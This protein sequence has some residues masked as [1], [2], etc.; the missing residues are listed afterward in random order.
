MPVRKL[1]FDNMDNSP[2]L[3]SKGSVIEGLFKTPQKSVGN[4]VTKSKRTKPKPSKNYGTPL[5][6][7]EI[8]PEY[9]DISDELKNTD[10]EY[11]ELRQKLIE[12]YERTLKIGRFAEEKAKN[13]ETHSIIKEWEKRKELDFKKEALENE[14]LK[15]LAFGQL[16]AILEKNE[17]EGLFNFNPTIHSEK[18]EAPFIKEKTQ[19]LNFNPIPQ[20]QKPLFENTIEENKIKKSDLP[21]HMILP[22][23][24]T[25]PITSQEG[26]INKISNPFNPIVHPSEP[27]D[28]LNTDKTLNINQDISK[29]QDLTNESLS[30]PTNEPKYTNSFFVSKPSNNEKTPNPF[31]TS[32]LTDSQKII[33]SLAPP[34]TSQTPFATS[35]N[36][37][38]YPSQE[39]KGFPAFSAPMSQRTNSESSMPNVFTSNI[40]SEPNL[41]SNIRTEQNVFASNIRTE[42][43]VFTSNI[44]TEQNAFTSNIRP[45]QNVFASN[46]R[47]EQNAFTSNIRTE[48]NVFTSNI[49]T[50]PNVFSSNT[51]T[52]LNPMTNPFTSNIRTDSNFFTSNIR[53][54]PNAFASNIRTEP[55]PQKTQNP[56]SMSNAF[57]VNE[58]KPQNN[59]APTNQRPQF[60]SV[61]FPLPQTFK[62][63]SQPMQSPFPAPQ[64]QSDFQIP[65]NPFQ[66]TNPNMNTRTQNTINNPFAN[67][68][69]IS[70]INQYTNNQAN[71]SISKQG[72][73]DFE[74]YCSIR[75]NT[76]SNDLS[77]K[78]TVLEIIH[79]LNIITP[80]MQQ[81]EVAE[82]IKELCDIIGKTSENTHKSIIVNLAYY[83]IDLYSGFNEDLSMLMNYCKSLCDI[84]IP[85]KNKFPLCLTAIIFEIQYLA[86]V[87]IPINYDS[88]K[89]LSSLRLEDIG[90]TF[91]GGALQVK[92]K[93][94]MIKVEKIGILF[95]SLYISLDEI[96]F[97]WNFLSHLLTIEVTMN[98]I[99]AIAGCLTF[100]DTTFKTLKGQEYKYMLNKIWNNCENLE[101]KCNPTIYMPYISMI[102]NFYQSF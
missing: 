1:V 12:N 32:N 24:T 65:S 28:R 72:S 21:P 26:V 19:D 62:P 87:F 70:T 18:S 38:N 59:F 84:V 63:D 50:E 64:F 23:Y 101:R 60:D 56:F 14:N 44:R 85:V 88:I 92:A 15:K 94:E 67:N 61:P 9:H 79:V 58:S 4:I 66:N 97:L 42:Q 69:H 37:V 49:R 29:Q 80:N 13:P 22:I 27:V 25:K 81:R 35:A 46:I 55:D 96:V 43:N 31:A 83:F 48:P 11:Q 6:L 86:D 52:E 51:R 20:D 73:M 99:P 53:T 100:A 75:R 17:S 16:P 47:P 74:E 41:T 8:K 77:I 2:A 102:K 40:K 5:D 98:W 57:L 34:L 54:E 7:K 90:R 93:E 39:S 45:E 36:L 89:A 30:T 68:N 71:I 78:N 95:A 3:S 33:S 10:V 91:K 76:P 82:C